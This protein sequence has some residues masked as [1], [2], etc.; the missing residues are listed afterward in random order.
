VGPLL[1]SGPAG[2]RPVLIVSADAFNRS[3]LKTVI[4]AAVYS[5]LKWAEARG[6]VLVRA[7]QGGLERD[8]VV[9]VSQL[10]TLDK[11]ELADPIGR[12]PKSLMA[13][14]DA[15]LRTVLSL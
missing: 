4:V 14:V 6:N 13:G 11:A 5:N 2:R 3:L 9:N 7:P 1:G 12:L 8:S 15:G 10:E